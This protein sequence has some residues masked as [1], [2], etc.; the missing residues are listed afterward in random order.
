MATAQQ[1]R[2]PTLRFKDERG[3]DYPEWEI[4]VLGDT[5]SPEKHSF[6]GGP[7]GSNL[8]NEDYTKEGVRI[9]QLQ[10][11][12]DGV[13][14]DDYRIYTSSAK[15]DELKSCNIFPSE[16]IISKMG[17]PVARACLIPKNKDKRYLMASDGIR[18]SVDPKKYNYKFIHDSINHSRF[19]RKATSHS[20]GSTRRRI[21]LTDLRKLKICVPQ[22]KEQQKIAAFLSSVDTKIEQLSRKKA[23]WERYKQGMMQKLFSQEIRFKD[24]QGEDYPE[25]EEKKLSEVF[26]ITR[27]N[28]LAI[29]KITSYLE[30]NHIYPVFSSQTRNNGLMGYY[31]DYLYENAI[32][33][34]TDGANAGEVN[35]RDGRFYCTN[36]CGVLLSKEGFANQ[37]IAQMLN[38]V[39]RKYVSYVG[40][41]KLMNNVMATIKIHFPSVEEQQKIAN[42]LSA[43]EQKIE[44]VEEQLK[45]AQIFKKG[46]LQ[47]MF[48]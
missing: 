44:L 14:N 32:T 41:P 45:Q 28:V 40:N 48:I 30:S 25:W 34:T 15:A 9:I 46:L 16:I 35:Y 10:N 3:E 26:K 11:I 31:T 7:F 37:C 29:N 2:V 21:G 38:R 20:T 27:G 4:M 18:L 42:F 17:D 13:F 36:V 43:I 19:R 22:L 1:K 47:Q 12:G 5:K 33:W 23:L 6:T 8:K 24:E 39:T